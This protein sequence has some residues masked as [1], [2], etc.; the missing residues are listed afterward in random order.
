MWTVVCGLEF[1]NWEFGSWDGGKM[2]RVAGW[3]LSSR[4]VLGRVLAADVVQEDSGEVIA[5]AGTMINE[6]M[7]EK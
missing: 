1:G 5:E 7:V 6:R 4:H 2:K 3:P